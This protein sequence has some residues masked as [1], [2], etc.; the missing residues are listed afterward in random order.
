MLTFFVTDETTTELTTKTLNQLDATTCTP[1]T[2]N[3]VLITTR[4]PSIAKSKPKQQLNVQSLNSGQPTTT[5]CT[6]TFANYEYEDDDNVTTAPFPNQASLNE[7]LKGL[8]P[9][10][11]KRTS[12]VTCQSV[13][14]VHPL[15]RQNQRINMGEE[16][17][18][19]LMRSKK[20]NNM[21]SEERRKMDHSLSKFLSKSNSLGG[22]LKTSNLKEALEV[23]NKGGE[24]TKAEES[25]GNEESID[26][27]SKT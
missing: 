20:Y 27:E 25:T 16:L 2:I 9:N 1:S 8:V 6:T 19:Q 26:Y 3:Q 14:T 13:T 11:P 5:A 15:N 22:N 10:P 21:S 24:E 7:Q 17:K 4:S 23:P 18:K 12:A